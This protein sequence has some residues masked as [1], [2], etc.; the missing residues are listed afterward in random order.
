MRNEE[1]I[2]LLAV[3][4]ALKPDAVGGIHQHIWAWN[5][6]S[7]LKERAVCSSAPIEGSSGCG[8]SCAASRRPETRSVAPRRY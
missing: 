5:Q 4:I 7:A 6:T 3:A 1:L 8:G 2:G